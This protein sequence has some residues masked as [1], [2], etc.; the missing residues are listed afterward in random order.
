LLVAEK[1]TSVW[2]VPGF[3][4]IR[5]DRAEGTGV[6]RKV[7]VVDVTSTPVIAAVGLTFMGTAGGL[8]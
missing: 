5:Y 2:L 7:T 6:H 1:G 3:K 8:R 4:R